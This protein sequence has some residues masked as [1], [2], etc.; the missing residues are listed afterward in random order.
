MDAD[1]RDAY[2]GEARFIRA[3]WYFNL[4]KTFGGVPLVTVPL[5]SSE[6][7]QA[8][9][10]TDEVYTL[11]KEDLE[12]AIEFLPPRSAYSLNALGRA[13]RG[14]AQGLM[15][16]VHAFLRRM[17]RLLSGIRRPRRRRRIQ[18]GS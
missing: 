6:Y 4:V 9:A 8:R 10:T 11:I 14:S 13:T 1:V 18:P 5:A 3:Y 15:T 17:G 12:F 2:L 16:K 7:Q